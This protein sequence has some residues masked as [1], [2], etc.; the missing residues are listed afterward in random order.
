M[1]SVQIRRGVPGL[2]GMAT[3]TVIA[4]LLLVACSDPAEGPPDARV[5]PFA[6]AGPPAPTPSARPPDILRPAMLAP[7]PDARVREILDLWL[8]REP[9]EAALAAAHA[10]ILGHRDVRFIAPLIELIRAGG[11]RFAHLDPSQV[12]LLG[13]LAGVSYGRTWDRWADWYGRTSLT[14]PPGFTGWKGR[15]MAGFDPDFATLLS[16]GAPSTIRVEMIAW[17]GVPVDGIVTLDAPAIIA[18]AEATYLRPDEPVYGVLLNGEARAYPLRIMDAHEMANDVL[19]GVPVAITHCPLCGS[20]V[21][22]DRRAPDGRTYTLRTSGLLFQSNKLMY[23]AETRSLWHQFTGRP[24]IGPLVQT[25]AGTDGAWLT[26]LPMVLTTWEAWLT[27]HPKTSVLSLETGFGEG[28][29]PGLPY[30]QYYTTADLL[31]PVSNRQPLL[32]AK[33]WVYGIEADGAAKAWAGRLLRRDQVVNDRV[34]TT[35]V[36]LLSASDW[37]GCRRRPASSRRTRT[38]A[39]CK[40]AH[41]SA[42]PA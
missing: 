34:G 28:Y 31:F 15:V 3:I 16:D 19:G 11:A 39:A 18:A 20:G 42:P 26:V 27:A 23:D 41:T 38:W 7:I 13:A 40:C 22:Y 4:T 32:P 10:E 30:L 14:P 25:S 8:Q 24:V 21:A 2:A 33:S 9:D 37:G 12:E 36:V 17:G 6:P 5:T 29:S 35:D 1:G